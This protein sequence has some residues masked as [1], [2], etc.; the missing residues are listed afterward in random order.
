MTYFTR[1]AVVG[2]ITKNVKENAEIGKENGAD[3]LELR[4]DLLL[5]NTTGFE[6]YLKKDFEEN[7]LIDQI[8]EWIKDAKDSG[9][10]VIGTL[11]SKKEGGAFEGKEADRFDLIKK[12]IP[13]TD[14]IDIER[15]SAKK[16]IYECRRIAEK[17]N[18]KIVLSSHYF[19]EKEMPSLKKIEKILE[20]SFEKGADIAK[21][22]VMPE[23]KKAVL[24]LYQAGLRSKK[25]ER[26]CL[27]AM[28]DLG[29]QTRILAP[30][31]GSILSYG[32]IDEEAAPGQL[33]VKKIK[34]GFKLLGLL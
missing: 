28:G 31:Y 15:K 10:P 9:L 19:D 21:I 6:K 24:T 33:P 12:I 26:V 27:I 16:T 14:Y 4:F 29:K 11:R 23:T 3:I 30:F 22:A 34:E 1:P 7:A 13:D 5:T 17:Y 25:P 18:T 2:T 20:K 32:Y 8:K